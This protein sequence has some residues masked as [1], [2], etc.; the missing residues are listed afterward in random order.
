MSSVDI[1]EYMGD[2]MQHYLFCPMCTSPIV[3]KFLDGR[4]LDVCS[5]DCGFVHW[6][7]PVPVVAALVYCNSQFILA[8][9][10]AWPEGLFSLISGFLDAGEL[11][12]SA[13]AREVKEELGLDVLSCDFIGFYP[14]KKMN[15][16]ITAYYVRAEGTIFLNEEI[17]DIK[18][19]EK[20]SLIAFDFGPLKLGKVVVDD[21][22]LKGLISRV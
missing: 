15:Q 4:D 16:I 17:A 18:K 22:L 14:L 3:T 7:N 13:I 19:L 6:N 9:N 11:P 2:Q 10:R 1:S 5:G 8:R 21:A 20:D 12:S